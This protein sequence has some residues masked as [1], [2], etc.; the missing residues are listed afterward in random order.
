M[1]AI[2]TV[3]ANDPRQRTGEV[4]FPLAVSA[5]QVEEEEK[6]GDVEKTLMKMVSSQVMRS[7]GG[8]GWITVK[9]LT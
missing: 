9:S 2:M 8:K 4:R 3:E 7:L 6:V 1:S 5:Q